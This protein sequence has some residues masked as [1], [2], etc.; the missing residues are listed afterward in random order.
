VGL[1]YV[2]DGYNAQITGVYSETKVTGSGSDNAF[3][4]S[5]QFQF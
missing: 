5:M 4:V 2:I 3:N 1:N